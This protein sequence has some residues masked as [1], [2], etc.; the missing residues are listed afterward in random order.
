[1]NCWSQQPWDQSG[2]QGF[3]SCSPFTALVPGRI[4]MHHLSAGDGAALRMKDA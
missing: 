2:F 4:A 1:M 3:V